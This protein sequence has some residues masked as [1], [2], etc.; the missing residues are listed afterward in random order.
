M[1]LKSPFILSVATM[2]ATI[3]SWTQAVPVP[4]APAAAGTSTI[5]P[6]ATARGDTDRTHI[7]LPGRHAG[8]PTNNR[9]ISTLLA[10]AHHY[11]RDL[12]IPS[13]AERPGGEE[14]GGRVS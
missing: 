10:T 6:N 3:I 4:N 9:P 2:L 12:A 13:T 7:G 1:I 8:Q 11:H 14:D 5:W